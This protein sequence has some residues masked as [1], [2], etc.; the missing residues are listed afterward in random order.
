MVEI[1]LPRGL[2]RAEAFTRAGQEIAVEGLELDTDYGAVPMEPPED[3]ASALEAIGEEIFVV[4]G[5]VDEERKEALRSLER[6]VGVFDEG[7]IEH[8]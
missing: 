5:T 2:S 6:V 1:R 3:R 7:R 4:R 8:F